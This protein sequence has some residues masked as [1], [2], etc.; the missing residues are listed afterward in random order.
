MSSSAHKFSQLNSVVQENAELVKRIAC[1]LLVRL[2]DSVMLEDLIQAG[3]IGLIEAANNYDPSKGASFSTYASIRIKGSMLDEVRK[4]DWTPRSVHKN[5]R[6]VAEA[7]LSLE[8]LTGRRAK[9]VE[10][11]EYLGIS[12]EEYHKILKDSSGSKIFAFDDIGD[13]E[14]SFFTENIADKSSNLIDV[15]QQKDFKEKLAKVILSLPERERLVLVLYYEEELNLKEIA[16]VIGVTESRI[17][18]IL[19]K[20]TIRLQSR[21]QSFIDK[22]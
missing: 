15:L 9:D 7:T 18:Q 1:H 14:D 13:D 16:E 2:P 10:V 5:A 20:A 4:G 12:M 19:G 3:M 21:M 6:T 8:H 22:H 11:A 17:S